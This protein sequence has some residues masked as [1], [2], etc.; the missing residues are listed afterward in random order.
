MKFGKYISVGLL[1]FAE[2]TFRSSAA[3]CVT[4]YIDFTPVLVMPQDDQ[5]NDSFGNGY[6]FIADC[7]IIK[8]HFS[9]ALG[10]SYR[11]YFDRRYYDNYYRDYGNWHLSNMVYLSLYNLNL[12]V[13][14]DLIENRSGTSIFG[15]FGAGIYFSDWDLKKAAF[16]ENHGYLYTETGQRKFPG[17]EFQLGFEI[18]IDTKISIRSSLNYSHLLTDIR[19]KAREYRYHADDP[20]PYD[21]E[22]TKEY[23]GINLGGKLLG[24]GLI[25]RL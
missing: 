1:V 25:Y 10:F 8:D 23:R 13:R 20:N 16:Y 18:P 24:I 9:F 15:A 12:S 6:G 21:V 4:P 14:G 2:M 5:V 3:F 19:V 7:G 22:F 11:S 17:F